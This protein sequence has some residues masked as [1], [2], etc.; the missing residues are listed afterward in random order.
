[1]KTNNIEIYKEGQPWG[2]KLTNVVNNK[3]Y[4]GIAGAEQTPD[5]YTTS[6]KNTELLSAISKGQVERDIVLADSS[7]ENIKAWENDILK[8]N[9]AE[10]NALSYN[11]SNG[12]LGKVKEV[13]NDKMMK[14]VA[15]DITKNNSVA[16]V[17][18]HEMDLT[19]EVESNNK[20]KLRPDSVLNNLV[21]LQ[22][23]NK[24]SGEHLKNLAD[25]IDQ[26]YGNLDRLEEDTG[27][28]LLVVVLNNRLHNGRY[29]RLVIGG[30]HTWHATL[31]SKLGFKVRV[32]E[33][34][35]SVHGKWTDLEI[36]ILGQYLNPRDKKTILETNEDDAVK[37]ALEIYKKTDKSTA[38]VNSYLNNENWSP[39]Q[40]ARIKQRVGTEHAKWE[41][42]K[43]RP[44]NFIDYSTDAQNKIL[45]DKA[46][47]YEGP[48]TLV[49][50]ISTG[51]ASIGDPM[52]KALHEIY[53]GQIRLEKI[54]IILYHPNMIKYNDYHV[55]WKHYFPT[56]AKLA[57][58]EGVE[59]T[60][61]EM[62][63][64]I[65]EE[66]NGNI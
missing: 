14:A 43:N 61:V 50:I 4:Y 63:H 65:D 19:N 15:D 44:Q 28:K 8:K 39:K 2:Y 35:S 38:A 48:N 5:T 10:N 57:K 11:K 24:T 66:K 49:K 53:N 17:N 26:Y 31:K 12:I 46:K 36:R 59:L 21:F 52:T 16:G 33:I 32:L 13:V 42:L 27:Q 22:I 20:S 25:K 60:W 54:V 37:T 9:N 30:N 40:K 51:K 1:M 47:E 34:P 6:S 29:V 64:L 55:K 3:F 7:F 41:E 56:W 58:H 45:K 62:P 18:I 23:R